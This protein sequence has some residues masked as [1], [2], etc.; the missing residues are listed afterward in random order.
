MKAAS[1]GAIVATAVAGVD[2]SMITT[3][4]GLP[5]FRPKSPRFMSRA[6]RSE[7]TANSS[8]MRSGCPICR[9]FACRLAVR[10]SE[11]SPNGVNGFRM[12]FDE[13]EQ[14]HPCGQKIG[15]VEEPVVD[16]TSQAYR[17]A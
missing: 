2:A 6:E 17:S 3:S 15:T 16:M 5:T 9:M 13:I 12:L 1:T 4:A 7:I 8:A 14:L 11:P 10:I